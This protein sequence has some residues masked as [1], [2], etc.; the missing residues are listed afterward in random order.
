MKV[1]FSWLI[2]SFLLGC[3]GAT[4]QERI[5]TDGKLPDSGKDV[6]LWWAL[7]SA[8]KIQPQTAP[9]EQQSDAVQI[10]CARN[11]RE[12]VQVVVRTP[13]GLHNLTFE[14]DPFTATGQDILSS[15][16]IEILKAVYVK[17]TTP[18]DKST[19]AGSWPDPLVPF[20]GPTD[21]EP[22]LNQTFWIRLYVPPAASPG[23]YRGLL[24]MRAEGWRADVPFALT[25]Y[26]FAL[27]DQMTCQTAFGFSPS[28][29][30]RY[31]G[32]Q[33]E[34]SKRQVLDM[35]WADLAAHHISPYDPAPLDQMKVTWPDVHPPK[36]KWDQ[37]SNLRIVHNEC[38]SGNG[39]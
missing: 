31:Q 29:V 15:T 3:I 17:V 7:S 24:R 38:H 35:Y 16:N 4:G 19:T 2:F 30:F 11:E 23:T 10:R 8:T 28:E 21:L 14:A 33:N 32:L 13:H 37:W 34:S 5:E 12:A 20:R 36:T 18:T 27:P 1:R 26:D 22:N 9:P 25:V 6:V 39:A